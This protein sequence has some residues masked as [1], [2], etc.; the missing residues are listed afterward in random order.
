MS[1][2]NGTNDITFAGTAEANTPFES[3]GKGKAPA[4]SEDHP[5]GEA[6]DDEDDEDEDETEEDNL[7][8]IDPSNVITGPRT[9]QKEIDYA[10]AAQDLPAEE[11]D[12]EDDEEFVPEDE[13]MEE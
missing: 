11:D 7:E 2:E 13:E 1:T 3:K 9:R 12:E 6:E 5:M 4:Q 8:E 10:K